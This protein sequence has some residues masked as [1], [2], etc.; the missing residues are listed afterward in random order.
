MKCRWATTLLECGDVCSATFNGGVTLPPIP[1]SLSS[2]CTLT[3]TGTTP[4]SLIYY[5]IAVM[6][7]DYY[8]SNPTSPMSSAPLQFIVGVRNGGKP[9]VSSLVADTCSSQLA[10]SLKCGNITLPAYASG[11]QSY[12]KV[13]GLF[14]FNWFNCQIFLHIIKIIQFYKIIIFTS[15]CRYSNVAIGSNCST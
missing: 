10:P 5:P 12:S 6:L 2:N 8:P 4:A 9:C 14:R 3:Y 15:M 1:F 13:L 11:P 7:E